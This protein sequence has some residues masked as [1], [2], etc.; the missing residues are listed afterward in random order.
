M[1]QAR[2][3]DMVRGW[4]VGAFTPAAHTSDACEVAVRH[5]RAGDREPA[6]FHKLATEITLVLSGQVRMAGQEWG[7]GDI[8]VLEPGEVTDFE[9][10]TDAVNIIVK[11]PAAAGDKF[12][13]DVS[14][15][16]Q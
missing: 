1:R 9:A 5:Y 12:L 4:F 11:T 8:V 2:L 14:P 7:E 6:H 13:A 16:D 3:G 15:N 10:L